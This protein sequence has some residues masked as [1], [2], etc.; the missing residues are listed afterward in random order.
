MYVEGGVEWNGSGVTLQFVL[1]LTIRADQ[2]S[3]YSTDKYLGTYKFV[4]KWMHACSLTALINQV[5]GLG[6]LGLEDW[7]S[8]AAGICISLTQCMC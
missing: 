8:H 4:S 2:S 7:F 6:W 1:Y 3:T 5:L